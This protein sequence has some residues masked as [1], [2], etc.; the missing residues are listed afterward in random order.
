MSLSF[1]MICFMNDITT[2]FVNHKMV[3]Y[4]M[5]FLF[6]RIVHFPSFFIYRSWYLLFCTIYKSHKTWKIF[7]YFL[8]WSFQPLCNVVYLLWNWYTLSYQSFNLLNVSANVASDPNQRESQLKCKLCKG[9]NRPK[10]LQ[11][12]L[13]NPA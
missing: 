3:L 5:S 6:S 13:L 12:Y 9:D 1:F 2:M 10:A 11:I 8:C 7:L 4:S